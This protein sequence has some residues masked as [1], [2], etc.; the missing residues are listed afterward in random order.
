[1]SKSDGDLYLDPRPAAP[2]R[3]AIG[4]LRS[5]AWARYGARCLWN[6]PRVI[7]DAVLVERLRTDGDLA[8]C[9]L[10]DEIETAAMDEHGSEDA[11]R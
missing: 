7:A 6:T 8:A 11:G 1:M 4:D 5:A 2:I 3:R 9:R 10:A